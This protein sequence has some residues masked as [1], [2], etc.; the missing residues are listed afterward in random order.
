MSEAPVDPPVS[1]WVKVNA[2]AFVV[3]SYAAW[4]VRRS[5][6]PTAPEPSVSVGVVKNYLDQL[7]RPVNYRYASGRE[8]YRMVQAALSS[9][10]AEGKLTTS[11]GAGL[12]GGEVKL[13]EPADGG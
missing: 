4:K 9:L 10:V 13:Y 2:L 3:E 8:Q 12:R 1:E 5:H 11:L 7:G 6:A